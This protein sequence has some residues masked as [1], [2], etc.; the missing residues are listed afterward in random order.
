MTSTNPSGTSGSSRRTI[1]VSSALRRQPKSCAGDI[2][3]CRAMAETLAPGFRVSSMRAILASTD[4]RRRG[5]S[6][7]KH[8]PTAALRE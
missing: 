4:Q 5:R 2:P 3:A 8:S 7:G 6:G 1:P